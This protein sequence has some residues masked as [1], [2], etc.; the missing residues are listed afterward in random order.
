MK[1]PRR[2]RLDA[3]RYE[4]KSLQSSDDKKK[5]RREMVRIMNSYRIK[6]NRIF[7][8]YPTSD[9]TIHDLIEVLKRY[10]PNAVIHAD[11]KPVS[12]VRI[13]EVGMDRHYLN[14]TEWSREGDPLKQKY[15]DIPR[16]I[17]EAVPN[18]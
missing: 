7:D 4:I 8:V 9:M 2:A 13:S 5:A 16:V 11:G 10:P 14:G 18:D 1:S 3:L 6:D 15:A 12:T 17:L